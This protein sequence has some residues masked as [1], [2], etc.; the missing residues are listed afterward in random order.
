MHDRPAGVDARRCWA[1]CACCRASS[2]PTSTSTSLAATHWEGFETATKRAAAGGVT[3]LV[4]M[5]LNSIPPT[6]TVAGLRRK[7]AAADGHCFVDVAFWGGV[8]PGNA[9]RTASRSRAPA[10]AA[11][12]ASSH[13]PGSR[14]SRT[15]A[16]QDLRAGDADSRRSASCRCSRTPSCRS[17]C[18]TQPAI[19]ARTRRG[20]HSRP[21]AAEV[22]AIA[23]LVRLSREFG[24]RVHIVHLASAEAVEAVSRA[25]AEGLP[26]TARPART[27]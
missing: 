7:A 16:R 9:A 3:T 14:S 12:S 25:R 15:S 11:S 1:S 20:L 8:V 4:D 24:T 2:I 19:R 6:T 17:V 26:I 5:P 22:A 18:R 23:L 21:P 13:R 27:T 10:C